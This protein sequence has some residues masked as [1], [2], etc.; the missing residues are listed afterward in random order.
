[1]AQALDLREHIDITFSRTIRGAVRE[2]ATIRSGSQLTV[3]G[4][5]VGPI[6]IE[7]D[8]VLMVQGSFNGSIQRNDGT[9]ILYGQVTLDLGQ[10]TGRLAVGIDSL[11]TTH[12]GVFRLSTDGE[13]IAVHGSQGAGSF[14]I[15]V[16]QVCTYA[17]DEES[18]RAPKQDAN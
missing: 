7:P 18:F 12:R 10:P 16:G 8:A 2:G 13:L 3:Q 15:H 6:I 14:N 11:I 5:F 9:L 4:S 1:M 17:E